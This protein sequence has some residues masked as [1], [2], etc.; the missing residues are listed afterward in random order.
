[1]GEKIVVECYL[2]KVYKIVL[3]I[4]TASGLCAASTFAGLKL[5]GFYTDV[6]WLGILLFFLTNIAYFATVI[7]L[8]KNRNDENG[9]LK[10]SMVVKAKIFLLIACTVQWSFVMFM[11]PSRDFWA[12]S[13][14]FLLLPALFLDNKL[15]AVLAVV[16]TVSM[17]IA[18]IV[19]ADELMPVKDDYF[20]SE[21][22]IRVVCVMLS[23]SLVL[24]FTYFCRKVLLNSQQDELENNNRK[25]KTIIE[26]AAVTV[27]K[28]T[29]ASDIVMQSI[30][31]ESSQSEELN[32]ISE[33][34][35]EMSRVI[36]EKSNTTR[37]T[38]K[39]LSDKSDI[40]AQKV[41]D[42]DKSFDELVH[43]SKSNEQAL[44]ELVEAST[45]TIEANKKTVEAIN[46]LV[47]GT[48]KINETLSIIETISGSTKLLALNASIEAAR[49][50]ESGKGFAVV[51]AEIGKLSSNTQES[52]KKIYE[53]ISEIENECVFTTQQV[54][55]SDTQ[56]NKQNEI[57]NTTVESIR[58]MLHLLD[59]AAQSV[60]EIDS[61]NQEQYQLLKNS[62]MVNNEITDQIST[63]NIQ[64]QQISNVVQENTKHIMEISRQMSNLKSIAD[65]L[66]TI[67]K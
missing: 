27:K 55:K 54:E 15:N 13:F 6:S 59:E 21:I 1:M 5:L 3:L 18:H 40:V 44:A 56:L 17:I 53:A 39:T 63:E 30:E 43:I 52:L 23:F 2:Q 61:L 26:K 47:S 67:F 11:L 45:G 66:Q 8:I 41:K 65:E 33:E 12:F 35:A 46:N 38:L 34:L 9:I 62:V 51:A 58:E 22:V 48:N 36:L 42:S 37:D 31:A 20:I 4:I 16:Y 60:K 50:G 10:D 57:I 28:L 29:E 24:L 32:A 7:I 64:F 14:F 49:A 25:A 19:R